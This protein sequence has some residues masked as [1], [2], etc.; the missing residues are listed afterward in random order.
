MIEVNRLVSL[1]SSSSNSNS[2]TRK[3]FLLLYHFVSVRVFLHLIFIIFILR[4]YIYLIFRLALRSSLDCL[5]ASAC[6]SY[7]V[8]VIFVNKLSFLDGKNCYLIAFAAPPR[9]MK[10]FGSIS[11]IESAIGMI[12]YMRTR[13]RFRI[14]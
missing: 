13:S 7:V 2:K 8:V 3:I 10:T 14:G 6:N 4:F 5:L 12:V 9:R 1:Y 11:T